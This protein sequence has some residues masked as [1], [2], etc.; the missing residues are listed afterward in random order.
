[1]VVQVAVIQ[2][3]RRAEPASRRADRLDERRE[4]TGCQSLVARAAH[5]RRGST[6]HQ[7]IDALSVP[8][9]HQLR[10]QRT[11]RVADWDERGDAQSVGHGDDVV[12]AVFEQKARRGDSLP[13]AALV[14]HDDPAELSH[15]VKRRIPR[16]Q[17]RA[18][19][20]VQ[21]HKRRRVRRPGVDD[22]GRPPT[23]KFDD[24]PVGH[25][26]DR[27]QRGHVG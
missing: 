5:R 3:R 14:E 8:L 26:P 6:Q 13:V 19:H 10:D 21:Q 16:H 9:P 25:L 17:S 4:N 24:T 20:R 15:L 2:R 7:P 22:K 1:M 11:H 27:R 12:R 23:G 18:G